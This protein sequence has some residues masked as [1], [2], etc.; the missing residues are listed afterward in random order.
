MVV[1]MFDGGIVFQLLDLVGFQI[2]WGV[3]FGMFD[4][5]LMFGVFVDVGFGIVVVWWD[6]CEWYGWIMD[7]YIFKCV[8]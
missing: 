6:V 1:V 4:Q 5:I 7:S 3:Y 8:C 2:Y